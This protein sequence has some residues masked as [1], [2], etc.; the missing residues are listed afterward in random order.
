MERGER[1]QGM[2]C[3]ETSD[4]PSVLFIL[5]FYGTRAP[6]IRNTDGWRGPPVSRKPGADHWTSLTIG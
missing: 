3:V 6:G 5:G 1:V 2:D 4:G